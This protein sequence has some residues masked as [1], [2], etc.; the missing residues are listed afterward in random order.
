M[1]SS[2]NS[3]FSKYCPPDKYLKYGTAGFRDKAYLLDSTFARMGILASL[4]SIKIQAS[5]GLM[6]TASHNSHEDNGIKLMDADGGMMDIS[7]EQYAM[8][9]ANASTPEKSFE[10]L[11]RIINLENIPKP[12]ID[13][14]FSWPPQLEENDKNLNSNETSTSDE[15]VTPPVVFIGRDTRSHSYHLSQLAIEGVLQLKGEVLDMGV[16]TT[17][18]L[19]HIVRYDNIAKGNID[20]LA[21]KENFNSNQNYTELVDAY[22]HKEKSYIGESGYYQML[23]DGYKSLLTGT[24]DLSLSSP[25]P[26]FPDSGYPYLKTDITLES[27]DSSTAKIDNQIYVDCA[28]GVGAVQ[29]QELKKVFLEKGVSEKYLDLKL[30][31]E[32]KGLEKKKINEQDKSID[33][34]DEAFNAAHLNVE[35][36]A[37]YVQKQQLPPSGEISI[38][39]PQKKF[40]SFDGDADRIVFHYFEGSPM[41]DVDGKLPVADPLMG[42]ANWHLLDGDK[43]AILIAF[44]LHKLMIQS[45]II[46]PSASDVDINV[47]EDEISFGV[48]QTAYANGASTLFLENHGIPVSFAKTGV[49]YVHHEAIKYDV[50]VYFEANG[51][52]T[53]IF[54]TKV[55][56]VVLDKISKLLLSEKQNEKH[57]QLTSLIRLLACMKLINQA[58]GDAISD[59][60]V[61]D[62]I[63]KVEA[64]DIGK[65]DSYYKDL[66]SKQAKVPV[67]DRNLV[68]CNEDEKT[69]KQPAILQEDLNGLMNELNSAYSSSHDPTIAR[70]FVRPS[71][72]EDVVRLYAEAK[73]KEDASVLCEKGIELVKKHL[74]S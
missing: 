9:F 7:W 12:D 2:L 28:Y 5:V 73:T 70:I 29:L 39:R 26:S 21:T 47:Q 44:F 13:K 17:P 32:P 15:V 3:F 1:W 53:V 67:Q 69:V 18:Q 68:K 55:R 54:S 35:C 19:H 57:L 40:C 36:G 24:M 14:N 25:L 64:Y 63:L 8:D 50:G 59:M 20:L 49:K 23:V 6:V 27:L 34:N 60:L 31:N 71:G 22:L 16:M 56:R 72:T 30:F 74:G 4:R 42:N 10:V 66:P 46:Q 11:Q 58:V 65:W 38:F 62:A 43:E 51:H 37:E 41:T 61:V 33:E 45:E 52:G 48:V